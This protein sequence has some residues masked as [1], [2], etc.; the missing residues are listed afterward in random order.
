MCTSNRYFYGQICH[1]FQNSNVHLF[2]ACVYLIHKNL[3]SSL[4]PPAAIPRHLIRHAYRS[5]RPYND[6]SFPKAGYLQFSNIQL[7]SKKNNCSQLSQCI[8]MQLLQE[9]RTKRSYIVDHTLQFL[10]YTFFQC[11]LQICTKFR[12]LPRTWH[13]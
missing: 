2:D 1:L 7:K 11:H 8:F 4:L 6:H 9:Y 3:Q 12:P 5:M 13:L 10:I